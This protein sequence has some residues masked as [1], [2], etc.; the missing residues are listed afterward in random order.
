[1]KQPKNQPSNLHTH[2][3]IMKKILAHLKIL[4]TTKIRKTLKKLKT[5]TKHINTFSI[6]LLTSRSQKLEV[7]VKLKS[8]QGP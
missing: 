6:S 7:K 3:L 4:C 2:V 8:D 1:M 5:P